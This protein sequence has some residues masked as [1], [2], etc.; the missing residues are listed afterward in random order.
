MKRWVTQYLVYVDYLRGNKSDASV[1]KEIARRFAVDVVED[2]G[3]YSKALK[4]YLNLTG[5]SQQDIKS[6]VEIFETWRGN[7]LGDVDMETNSRY[8]PRFCDFL[9]IDAP[10]A[11]YTPRGDAALG[12][13]ES[14]RKNGRSPI[15]L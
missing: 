10:L 6:L 15:T 3:G 8:K 9:V 14:C 7:T 5:A 13:S 2:Q 4:P 11:R 1:T 12:A